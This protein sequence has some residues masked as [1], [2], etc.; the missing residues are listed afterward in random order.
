MTRARFWLS[1]LLNVKILF[2]N[3]TG[4]VSGAERVLLMI[5]TRLDRSRFEPLVVRPADG[6]LKTMTGE[7]GVRNVDLEPLDARFTWRI[8]RLVR[9]LVSFIR[10]I[11]AARALI[12]AETP[13][14]IHANSIRAGLVMTAATSGMNV[15]VI[16]HAHDIL[17]RHPLSTAIRWYV[18]MS[19]R[20]SVLAVSRAVADRFSAAS[21][22]VVIHN[23][24]DLER[25]RPDFESRR[26]IRR[27][28]A[29]AEGQLVI[30]TVGQLTPRKGQRELIDA[31]AKVIREIPRAVL[32][33]VG[34]PLFNRDQ[35][36]AE[37]LRRTANALGIADRLRFVGAR[38]DIPALMRGLDVLVVNSRAEPFALTVLEGLAS[39]TP[40]LATA[41][42]GIPEM[43]RH[44]ENGWLVVAHDARPLADAILLLLRDQSLRSRIGEQGRREAIAR[45]S[46]ERFMREVDYLY[47]NTLTRGKT[48]HL[49]QSKAFELRPD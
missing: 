36:Y 5:L 9:Y 31:F 39:G 40:V 43:I 13:D 1:E 47:R 18:R 20:T 48:P 3:H 34:E 45:F 6:R 32:L 46:V 22:V 28:L 25:F 11:R 14:I 12:I 38:D 10:V 24:V 27:A 16:W 35:N 19:R 7:I 23:A 29:I 30:G 26:E 33:V 49:G 2:Y 8:D 41:V 4:Q 15:P 17:P 42:G 37:S 44:G 21:P